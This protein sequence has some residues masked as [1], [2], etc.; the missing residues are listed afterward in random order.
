ME[1]PDPIAAAVAAARAELLDPGLANPMVRLRVPRARGVEIVDERSAEV[2]RILVDEGRAMDFLPTEERPGD[3][4]AQ[5]TRAGV[6]GRH[7][8]AH[9]QTG[10]GSARL[11][12]RLVNTAHAARTLIEEQGH[13]ALALAL[14]MLHWHHGDV[15]LRSPLL[16]MP[17]QLERTNARCRYT[18]R[19][20]EAE[21]GANLSLAALLRAE[22]GFELPLPNV[23]E[24][25]ALDA[26]FDDFE[27]RLADRP[28]WRLA[29]DEMVLALF[30]SK[31]FLLY[32]DLDPDGWPAGQAPHAHRVVRAVLGA[33]FAR[34]APDT[35]EIE[36]T[37]EMAHPVE[38]VDADTSQSAALQRVAS[39]TD[40]VIQG[41]PGTGKSQTITNLVAQAVARGERVLFVA[42]KMA[43][44][45]VVHRRLEMVGLGAACLELHSHKSRKKAVLAELRRTLDLGPP[46]VRPDA[47]AETAALLAVTARL[48]GHHLA[49]TRAVSPSGISPV[50][51]IG[52]LASIVDVGALPPLPF[53]PM[54][55]W[56]RADH[57]T[58]RERVAEL[59]ARVEA[60]GPPAQHPFAGSRRESLSPVE[61]EALAKAIEVA[62]DAIRAAMA[63]HRALA[64]AANQSVP[65]GPQDADRLRAIGRALAE[66]PNISGTDA[67]DGRWFRER[68]VLG[69]ALDAA[70]AVNAIRN[71]WSGVLLDE[72]WPEDLL[73]ATPALIESRGA[74]KALGPKWWRWFAGRWR[75]AKATVAM[76]HADDLPD[77]SGRWVEALTAIVEGRRAFTELAALAPIAAS[78][79]KTRWTERHPDTGELRAVFEWL[80][81]VHGRIDD[82]EWPWKLRGLIG[83]GWD[84]ARLADANRAAAHAEGVRVEAIRTLAEALDWHGAPLMALPYG[85]L[86]DR[87][88]GW[89]SA[90][91]RLPDLCHYNRLAAQARAEG[92]TDVVELAERWPAAGERLVDAFDAA[93][94]GGILATARAERP[95]LA[96]FDR[97]RH[98]HAVERFCALDHGRFGHDRARVAAAH[99]AGLPLGDARVTGLSLLRREMEKKTR[100]LP[101]RRLFVEAGE[102]VQ[103]IKPVF[104]MSPMSV[105]AY[106]APEGPRFDVVIF[107]EASQVRPV[108]ALGALARAKRAVV[109]G[110]SKQMPPSR[111]FER[112]LDSGD[113]LDGE[114]NVTA[115]L[116][117]VLGL[118]VAAGATPCMLRWHYRSRHPSLVAVSNHLFYGDGLTLFPS[119]VRDPQADG[120]LGLSLHHLPDAIYERGE[121]R[122]NP[123]EAEAV[124]AAV[125]HHAIS[126]PER[127]LGV[128]AFS[129]AQMQ[130]IQQA[131]ERR[132]RTAVEGEAFFAA[133]VHEPFFVKNLENVQGDERDVILISVGYGRTAEGK[134]HAQFGPLNLDGGERR[135]NVLITRARRRCVV[136]TN[137]E[138]EQIDLSRTD[139]RG[140][141]ALRT[142]LEYARDGHLSTAPRQGAVEAPFEDALAAALEARG[143][144]VHRRV[145][146]SSADGGCA[147]PLAVVDPERP[148]RYLL[149]V[150][151]DGALGA[152]RTRDRIRL[153][154]AVLAGLG[155][156]LHRVWA[157]AWQRDP[158]AAMARLDAALAEARDEAIVEAALPEPLP[159]VERGPGAVP[160]PDDEVELPPFPAYDPWSGEIGADFVDSRPSDADAVIL[161]IARHEAPLSRATLARRIT[162]CGG[163][164]RCDQKVYD[165]V[166]RVVGRL[167]ESG[168]LRQEGYFVGLRG[169]GRPTPRNRKNLTRWE[170]ASSQIPPAELEAALI[171]T[172]RRARVMDEDALIAAGARRLGLP[173]SEGNPGL[174]GP[175]ESALGRL[176]A[177]GRARR[178]DTEIIWEGA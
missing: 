86:L 178:Y 120:E 14:G 45:D 106:L 2:W 126:T 146:Q 9:L 54:A 170:R 135:L 102:A 13:N 161:A 147:V 27:A 101:L 23:D 143:H 99:H 20:S 25:F 130:A 174:S 159:A 90:L 157:A 123:I 8:D 165:A 127:T 166:R 112:L 125:L 92:L 30:D 75:Q 47:D 33:G 31:R 100:H 65:D 97:V 61:S 177:D 148:E 57:V 64:E 83:R 5:P 87:L 4:L 81:A 118:F 24:D 71:P 91:D 68:A 124:A 107:D 155:W 141:A 169:G 82:G 117:S 16:L 15:E 26:F 139:A 103:R 128:V 41:P 56:R 176:I 34:E 168:A 10:Y 140:V 153:R 145:G 74:I 119:P 49:M 85:A 39:G 171:D 46:I 132:R 48:E 37:A 105:A 35:P 69:D 150:D 129:T 62:G 172:L 116:E 3:P 110:D 11:Q 53:G 43:A 52:R 94:Y 162:Q 32:R 28:S 138:P 76:L 42:E 164:A 77:D 80:S 17:A 149:G 36:R 133:H 156:R 142:F 84:T 93:W 73:V 88:R 152:R 22:H 58:R 55:D 60:L 154:P 131:I 121:S 89:R 111:F 163:A 115:D 134:V 70:D 158:T 95:P 63:A 109:V 104:L 98:L 113:L 7:V 51:A 160:R 108:D 72:A 96:D 44:L 151:C 66:A 1:N 173:R 137:L 18:V 6:P 29:R 21:I 175:W 59:Q 167:A 136:F 144:T 12:R 114:D 78:L 19:H 67:A 50:D 122:T 40:V 38:V 79:F